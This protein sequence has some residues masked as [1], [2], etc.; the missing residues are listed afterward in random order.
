MNPALDKFTNAELRQE[1]AARNNL[2]RYHM[3]MWALAMA[4]AAAAGNLDE[5]N[6]CNEQLKRLENVDEWREQ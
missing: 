6:K 5:L 1:L 3:T 4:S 2:A